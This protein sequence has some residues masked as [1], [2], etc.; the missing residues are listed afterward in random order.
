MKQRSRSRRHILLLEVLIAFALVALCIFPLIAP[1]VFMLKA[2]H[3]FNRK[4]A[5]DQ[6]ASLVYARILEKVYRNE[7]PWQA[8]EQKQAFPIEGELLTK[9]G[10][11]PDFASKG[12][13][14]FSISRQKGNKEQPFSA[15]VISVEIAFEPKG[16]PPK[17]DEEKR[18]KGRSVYK[19]QFFAAKLNSEY[20]ADKK[21]S[22]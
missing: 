5:L 14:Q 9:L 11:E 17:G 7:I 22:K 1:H 8:F 21:K 4:I 20:D 15:N 12:T 16:A 3:Q 6:T 18:E 13:Y 2:Q 10:L 19:Y